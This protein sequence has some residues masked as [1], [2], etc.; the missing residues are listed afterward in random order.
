MTEESSRIKKI[1]AREILDSRGNPTVEA[2]VILQSGDMGRASVPS[3][4]STGKWEVIE[5]R[6]KDKKRFNGKGVLE[7]VKNINEIISKALVGKDALNQEQID[8]VMINLDGT[9]QKSRL[10]GNAILAVSLATAKA[11]AAYMKMPLYKYLSK[12]ESYI[13]PVPLMNIINGGK[14]AGNELAIQEFKIIPYGADSFPEALRQGVETYQ[15]LKE[16]LRE[17]YGPSAVNVGDEGGFAPPMKSTKEALS[18]L[19]KAIEAAGYTEKEIALGLDAAASSFYNEKDKTYLIDGKKLNGGELLEYY[20]KIIEEFPLV[21]IED[22]FQ[23][24][25]YEN[26]AEF[27]K[28]FGNR[29]QIIG[30]DIFVTNKKKLEFGIEKGIANALLFK[31]NQIGTLTEAFSTMELALSKNYRVVV[32]H[33]SGETEDDYIAD[34]AVGKCTGEIK[35]GAPCRGERTAK[36][37]RLLR[38]NEELGENAKYIGKQLFK[39]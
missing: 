39:I 15:K 17:N 26:F 16:L 7:A 3:G 6:D 32:S 9:E 21:S 2:E 18:M 29:L 19:L 30:D 25:D 5:L 24:E 13:M 11:A 4:A 23:E 34:I 22:P 27:T 12:K 28:R 36:Y 1:H 14:H 35:T 33:R 8:E 10:G 31:V 37:N 20:S 38:I